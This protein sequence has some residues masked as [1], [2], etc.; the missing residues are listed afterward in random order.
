MYLK[1]I[2]KQK[3]A[4]TVRTEEGKRMLDSS[5]NIKPLVA[6]Q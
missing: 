2:H 6:D 5:E 4:L 3:N 1:E